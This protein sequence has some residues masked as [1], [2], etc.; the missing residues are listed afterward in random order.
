MGWNPGSNE[1]YRQNQVNGD[2]QDRLN[3]RSHD[4]PPIIPGERPGV[5]E[6]VRDRAR[7]LTTPL[8]WPTQ[9]KACPVASESSESQTGS[10]QAMRNQGIV[11]ATPGPSHQE[12]KAAKGETACHSGKQVNPYI[13][14]DRHKTSVEGP[15][16]SSATK[17]QSPP[18]P[19]IRP[20]GGAW[21]LACGGGRQ[22]KRQC[23]SVFI[24]AG[25]VTLR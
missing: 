13:Q 9:Y 6:R 1:A 17:A 18:Q 20:G 22:W 8:H 12:L 19:K 10:G 5:K 2:G 24:T 23:P 14:R 21:P 25:L 7:I 4:H 15:D 16:P 11:E 3:D